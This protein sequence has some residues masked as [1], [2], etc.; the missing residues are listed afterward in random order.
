MSETKESYIVLR[1]D[2]IIGACPGIEDAE[3]LYQSM[4]PVW[5]AQ[6]KRAVLQ[7]KIYKLVKEA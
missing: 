7:P 5:K 1:G 3:A 4:L 6:H 2:D